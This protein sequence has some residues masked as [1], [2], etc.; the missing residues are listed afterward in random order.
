[1]FGLSSSPETLHNSQLLFAICYFIMSEINLHRWTAWMPGRETADAWA[2]WASGTLSNAAAPDTV[3]PPAI[4]EI[5]PLLRRRADAMGRAVLHV[6]SRPELPYTGEAIVLCSR[7]GEFTRSLDLQRELASTGQVSP[8]QFSMAVHNAIG[9]LFMM[10][11]KAQAPLTALAAA[12]ETALA[13]LQEAHAQLA[14][15]APSV[16]LVYGEE[17]LAEAYHPLVRN[18]VERAQRTDFF[19]ILL[20]LKSG[21]DFGLTCAADVDSE[22]AA[23]SPLDLLRFFLNPDLR[24]LRL[25][26]KSGW[27]IQ[28]RTP[29]ASR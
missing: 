4:K 27:S 29:G 16:W 22:A 8:Q 14:D 24:Q 20:E 13:G 7:L 28:R 9:G 10:S 11:A 1:M 2:T 3:T 21:S 25:S 17:P 19:G 26:A 12:D 6:L 5:P 18:P 15:G 23:A